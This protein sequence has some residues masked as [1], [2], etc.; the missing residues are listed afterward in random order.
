ML[1]ECAARAAQVYGL[2]C[3]VVV[4]MELVAHE[5]TADDDNHVTDD[6][7]GQYPDEYGGVVMGGGYDDY[8]SDHLCKHGSGCQEVEG[9]VKKVC[10]IYEAHES[11]QTAG[12]KQTGCYSVDGYPVDG[13]VV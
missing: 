11:G 9:L 6:L 1:N 8:I 2:V 13:L 12:N 4:L 5:Q 3:L 10:M 7:G